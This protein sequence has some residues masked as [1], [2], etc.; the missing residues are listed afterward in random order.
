[1]GVRRLAFGPEDRFVHPLGGYTAWFTAPDGVGLDGWYEM[2]N[3][4]G[5][6]VGRLFGQG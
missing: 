6:L 5:G 4:P 1:M 3:E 2:Y